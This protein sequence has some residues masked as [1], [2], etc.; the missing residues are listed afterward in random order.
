M[1]TH[2]I[3]QESSQDQFMAYLAEEEARVAGNSTEST[4]ETPAPVVE[5]SKSPEPEPEKSAEPEEAEEAKLSGEQKRINRLTAEKYKA[6]AERDLL[7]AQL[8]EALKAKTPETKP[9]KKEAAE[10]AKGP[11]EPQLKDFSDWDEYQKAHRAYVTE[12]IDFKTA[13]VVEKALAERDS[14]Q[15]KTTQE[16]QAKAS[17]DAWKTR[18]KEFAVK[19][20]DYFE[21]VHRQ[22]L[23]ISAVAA[24]AIVSEE[25]GT[26]IAYYLGKNQAEADRIRSLDD[27]GQAKAIGRLAERLAKPTP[28][29]DTPAP[30]RKRSEA[31]APPTL[32]SGKSAPAEAVPDASDFA[33]FERWER[34][35]FPPK[36][37]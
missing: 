32:L 23:Q 29:A 21:A 22:D 36:I 34:K 35:H 7:K 26:D 11:A 2:E 18:E 6:Q 5:E 28:A 33:A 10:P 9:E 25:N 12:L 16:Q 13:Q 27:I 3:T 17:E 24:R 19:N 4:E 30:P 31:P 8:D 20:P 14:K 37:R 1:Q 15:A